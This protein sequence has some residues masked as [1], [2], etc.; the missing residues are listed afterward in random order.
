[1]TTKKK[2]LAGLFA[3]AAIGSTAGYMTFMRNRGIVEVQAGRVLRQDL[4]Q[5]VTANGEIKPKKSVN[6]SSNMMGR[7]VSMPVKEGDPVREGDLLVRLESIQTEAEVR[8]AQ[9]NLEAAQ[10]ELEG[11]DA[12]IRSADATINAARA[13]LARAQAD[14]N[15]AQQTFARAE[16]MNRDGLIS[17]EQ[18]ERTKAEFDIATAQVNANRARLAQSEAQAAQVLKQKEGVGLRI[19]QQRSSLVRAEDQFS[20]ATIM[21][22]LEGVITYLP[23]NVGEI[24]IVGVQNQAGTVLMT[25]ADMSVITAEVKV[26]ETDIVNVKVGQE[27]EIRVDALGDRVLTGH[28]SEVGN[29]A[30]TR[31]GTSATNTQTTTDEARDFK[32]IITLDSPPLELKTGL[33]CTASIRTAERK[34]VLTIPIQALTVREFEGPGG[35]N[36][37]K[38]EKEGVYVINSGTAMFREVKTGIVGTTDIEVTDGLMENEEIVIGSFQVLRTLKDNDRV[39]IARPEK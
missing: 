33:S 27:A 32:V 4:I 35:P 28:V 31:S 10:S 21:S 36:A 14:L 5:M 11:M 20:K 16:Q 29:T 19:T 7:I 2:V 17:K 8:A 26:D 15:R 34:S 1:M 12:S 25:I 3:M 6:I 30:L 13:E 18:Y 38:V 23:V 37:R 22:P 9:A 24:A 39:R